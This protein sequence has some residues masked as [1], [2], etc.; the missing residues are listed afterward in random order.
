MTKLLNRRGVLRAAGIAASAPFINRMGAAARP[1]NIL[2]IMTDQ[3]FADA[4]SCR[5]GQRHIRTP[6]M[7]S[8]AATGTLFSRAYCPNP[9]CVPSRTSMFSGRYPS[10]TGVQTNDLSPLDS[11]RFPLMG[12]VFQRAG[13]ATAYTGKWHLPYPERDPACHG[14]RILPRERGRRDDGIAAS[15]A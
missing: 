2:L 6:A 7:D 1:P 11:K 14:F 3:Q 8:L 5:I 13:Y 12:S 4:M 15:A 9:I 10:E